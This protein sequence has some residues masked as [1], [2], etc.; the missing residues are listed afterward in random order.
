MNLVTKRAAKAHAEHQK[1]VRVEEAKELAETFQKA[2]QVISKRFDLLPA[3]YDV[4][5]LSSKPRACTLSMLSL[6]KRC[7]LGFISV[8]GD[9]MTGAE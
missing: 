6:L 7:Q 1:S 5:V 2:L 4:E 9:R 3:D 8:Q